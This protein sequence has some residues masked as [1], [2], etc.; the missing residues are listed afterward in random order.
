MTAGPDS[1]DFGEAKNAW[2]TGT[3]SWSFV[4]ISQYI[5]G[6][7]PGFD[8]LIVDPCIPS[9]WKQYTVHRRYRGKTYHIHITNPVGVC[10]GVKSMTANGKAITGNVIPLNLNGDEINVEVELGA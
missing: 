6:V 4:V 9:S 3:A 2:L 10:R 5:L 7:R 8:G 1:A